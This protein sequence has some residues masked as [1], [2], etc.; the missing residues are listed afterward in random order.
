M[1]HSSLRCFHFLAALCSLWVVANPPVS[2]LG[3]VQPPSSLNVLQPCKSLP[4]VAAH[5]QEACSCL[6]PLRLLRERPVL[7]HTPADGLHLSSAA[8]VAADP[9]LH[10]DLCRC[11]HPCTNNRSLGSCL[12]TPDPMTSH[13]IRLQAISSREYGVQGH[14]QSMAYHAKASGTPPVGTQ[15]R[16]T[17]TGDMPEPEGR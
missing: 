14:E 11:K 1:A 2:V 4:R 9:P 6:Q 12:Q 3:L 13:C 5:T 7:H 8:C 10:H 15:A 16:K 17:A